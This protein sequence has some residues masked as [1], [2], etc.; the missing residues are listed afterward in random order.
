VNIE[1]SEQ[2]Y[3]TFSDAPQQSSADQFGTKGVNFRAFK[4]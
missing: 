4:P 1:F 3:D 2:R